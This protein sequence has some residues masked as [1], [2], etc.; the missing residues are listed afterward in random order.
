MK[1]FIIIGSEPS[2]I[3]LFRSQ[4]IKDISNS[5][6][7][8][9]AVS[10]PI[11][12]NLKKSFS[13]LKIKHKVIKFD[14]RSYNPINNLISLYRLTMLLIKEKPDIVLAYTIKPVIWTGIASIFIKTKYYALITGLG[15]TFHGDSYLRRLLKIFVKFLYKIA[16]LNSFKVIFQNE[17][18]K[19]VFI[20]GNIIKP[21]KA[22]LVNGS[23]VDINFYKKTLIPDQLS[24]LQISRLLGEKGIREYCKAAEIIKDE[25][26]EISFNLLGEEDHSKDGIPIE[27]IKAWEN[28]KVINYF[29][30][31]NDVRPYIANSSVFVLPSYHEGISRSVLE[32]M[33]MGRPIIT[34]NA[35]GCKETVVN[36]INGWLVGVGDVNQLVEKMKW[37]VK[38]QDKITSMG[39]ESL[40]II[41]GKFEIGLVNNSMLKIMDIRYK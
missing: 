16:M 18:N 36:G 21:E 32:A 11:T 17:D 4:L 29:T 30:P 12:S 38:N 13:N 19:K 26:P 1:K 37:F 41:R 25:F 28:K 15:Y 8:V 40:N 7:Q 9:I 24:F 5:N 22:C 34:T 27:E 39:N 31:T 14:R 10:N 6:F 33:S 3:L 20:D 23:G 35:P 2:S